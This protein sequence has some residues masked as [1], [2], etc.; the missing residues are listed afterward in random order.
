M[1]SDTYSWIGSSGG[2]WGL[3]ANW[4]DTTAGQNP[5]TSVPGTNNPVV[6]AGPT[7]SIY[8]VIAGGG[9]AASIA[10]T[11]LIDLTGT[12]A[13]GPLTIGTVQAG[14][15]SFSG[16]AGNL[17]LGSVSAVSAS[18]VT[19]ADGAL[20]LNGGGVALTASGSITI[21]TPS[22]YQT[23]SSSS[24][25][26]GAA[27]TVSVAGGATITAGGDLI[28]AY[29]SVSAQGGGTELEVGGDLLLG[30]PNPTNT[31]RPYANAE[32]GNLSVANGATVAIA[33]GLV[34]YYGYYYGSNEI[35]VSGAGSK[36]S[37]AGTATFDSA[38][39]YQYLYAQS[40]GAI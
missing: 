37:V 6:I 17:E 18:V 29:G 5:A 2:P 23:S 1:S 24:Y 27:G 3:A 40:G 19:V 33:G 21:G 8:E 12:Y 14:T 20:S 16:T 15:S 34:E 13:T 26:N 28:V 32:V 39:Y 11:G 35:D 10:L 9:T 22:G 31:T 36:L 4:A 38:P 25:F 7:G 30:T